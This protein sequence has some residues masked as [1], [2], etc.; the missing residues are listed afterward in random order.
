MQD[1]VMATNNA[2]K[3]REMESLLQDF[4][5]ISLK[6]VGFTED[7][8]EPYESFE[9]NALAKAQTVFNFCRKNI[10]ADDSGLCVN[11]LNGNPGVHS[12]YYGGLPRSNEKNNQVLLAA[13]KNETN[14]SAFYKAVICLMWQ[15]RPYFFEGI[16]EGEILYEPEGNNGFGYDPLFIPN[17][18]DKSFGA[19]PFAI[20]NEISHRSKAVKKM[21]NFL[22]A[23]Q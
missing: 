9:E 2:G 18:F 21:I 22:K 20:K 15:G 11:A 3:I 12:A 7:I 6:D 8:P 13:L 4:R 23:A 1:L 10:F 19:L 17:G 5:L 16:C 14:R